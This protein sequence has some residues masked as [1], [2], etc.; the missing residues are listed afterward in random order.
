LVISIKHAF[1][2]GICNEDVYVRVRKCVKRKSVGN[3]RMFNLGFHDKL[4]SLYSVHWLGLLI[5]YVY[6]CI[7]ADQWVFCYCVA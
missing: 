1:I 4:V 2:R 5:V 6:G 3:K 7:S